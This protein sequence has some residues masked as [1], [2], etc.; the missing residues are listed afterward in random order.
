MADNA[1]NTISPGTRVEPPVAGDVPMRVLRSYY[2]D[3]RGGRG[4]GFYVDATMKKAAF[5]DE[6]R[7]LTATRTDPN[8]IRDMVAIAQ[9]RGWGI[10]SVR[11]AQDFR[12]ESWLASTGAGLEV[13]GYRPTS[14][15][16]QDLTRRLEAQ[17]RQRQRRHHD[18]SLEWTGRRVE[19]E[20]GPRILLKAVETVVRARVVDPSAQNRILATARDRLANWLDRGARFDDLEVRDRRAGRRERQR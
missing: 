11:G 18:P 20:R 4:V 1:D 9:H 2:T 16:L 15:D 3:E 6:G 12:R 10:V 5:R 13:R 7:K 14:R 19:T 17:A 8:T